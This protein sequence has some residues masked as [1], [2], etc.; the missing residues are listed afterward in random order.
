M[1]SSSGASTC[2]VSRMYLSAGKQLPST[3]TSTLTS[4]PSYQSRLRRC[5][6]RRRCYGSCCSCSR[7]CFCVYLGRNV[8]DKRR[9]SFCSAPARAGC[10]G[11]VAPSHQCLLQLLLLLLLDAGAFG[12]SRRDMR[13]IYIYSQ[14]LLLLPLPSELFC[15][16]LSC[17]V[18]AP[19]LPP[20]FFCLYIFVAAGSRHCSL[21]GP[22]HNISL[23]PSH[24]RL[25][26]W[27]EERR[28]RRRNRQQP[29]RP[30]AVSKEI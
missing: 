26:I 6:H 23:P 21:F 20:S 1:T 5:R 9:Y 12:P 15:R 14:R 3:S 18:P 25:A 29:S 24:V 4:T 13:T 22:R 8:V 11:P 2:C 30:A 16:A 17:P 7:W 28:D 27:K 19:S 10:Y